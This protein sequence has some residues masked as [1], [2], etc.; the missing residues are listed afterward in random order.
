MDLLSWILQ[1]CLASSIATSII[2]YLSAII[3]ASVTAADIYPY[4]SFFMVGLPSIILGIVSM[5]KGEV[6]LGSL[7]SSQFCVVSTPEL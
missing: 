2:A 3:L 7:G 5:G 4:A 6:I 1:G